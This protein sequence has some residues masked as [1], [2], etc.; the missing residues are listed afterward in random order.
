MKKS[1]KQPVEVVTEKGQII[2]N[3][4]TPD[5]KGDKIYL[6]LLRP[7]T[8]HSSRWRLATAPRSFASTTASWRPRNKAA[9]WFAGS[10]GSPKNVVP[11]RKTA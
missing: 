4:L 11:I 8:P 3:Y 1:A 9:A 10:S 2:P 7:R 5:R 6:A